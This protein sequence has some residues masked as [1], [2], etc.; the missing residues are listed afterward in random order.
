MKKQTEKKVKEAIKACCDEDWSKKQKCCSSGMESSSC[1][2]A[3]YLLG[4]IGAAWYYLSV[5]TGFWP[6]VLAILKA[7]VWPAFLVFKLLGV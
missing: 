2:G 5:T 6:S 3:F 7:F 1:F 4:V